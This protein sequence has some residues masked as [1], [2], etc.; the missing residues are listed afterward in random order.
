MMQT[1]RTIFISYRRSDH[2]DFAARIRDWLITRYGREHVFMDFDSI[3]PFVAFADFIKERIAQS[4]VVLVLIGPEWLSLL[5]EKAAHVEDYIV[6]ELETALALGKR[7]APLLIKGASMPT[8][9]DL[10]ASLQPITQ[11]NAAVVEDGKAF[12]NQIE[13]VIAALETRASEPKSDS[14]GSPDTLDQTKTW[15]RMTDPDLIKC[16]NREMIARMEDGDYESVAGGYLT[17]SSDKPWPLRGKWSIQAFYY[18]AGQAYELLG[19]F[20]EAEDAYDSFS[21]GY[22]VKTA[23]DDRRYILERLK[24]VQEKIKAMEEAKKAERRGKRWRLF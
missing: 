18:H 5:R 4:D 6:L 13:A 16:A 10:P 7:V 22:D 8:P 23:S 19:Q 9:A 20:E 1:P 15:R 12:Y 17:Y 24:I 11:I 21:T 2:P 14:F 3:P